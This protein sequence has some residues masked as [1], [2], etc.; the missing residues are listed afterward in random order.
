M[1]NATYRYEFMWAN[2]R[3]EMMRAVGANA[4]ASV[5]LAVPPTL[6]AGDW[7]VNVD[8]GEGEGGTVVKI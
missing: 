1:A 2:S 6:A 4:V 3:S 8:R 5:E 7:S